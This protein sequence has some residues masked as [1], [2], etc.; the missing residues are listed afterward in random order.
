MVVTVVIL[1]GVVFGLSRLWQSS[2]TASEATISQPIAIVN[3]VAITRQ[4]VDRELKVS[5]LNVAAPLPPLTGADLKRAGEEALNQLIT[6][7]LI[8]QAATWQGFTL[9]DEFIAE[10]ARLLFGSREDE[11]LKSA[12]AHVEA[13]YADLLWWVGEI[14]TIEEFTTQ[15]IMA[16]AAPAKRQQVYN[17]WFNAQR[18]QAK[19]VTYAGG[20]AQVAQAALPGEVATNFTLTTPNGQAISLSDYAGKVVLVN[21]WA[22]WCLSCISEMPDYEQVYQQK[23]P[24]LVVLGINLQEEA[25]HAQQYAAG[26]GVTFPILMDSDGSV[27]TR[28]YQVTGMPGSFIIDRNGVIFYRHLGP[29][30][31]ETLTAK[32]AE[33]GL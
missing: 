22:T 8:L 2:S 23:S 17:E 9:D 30:N 28:H 24:E 14:I 6:R 13:S 27:T 7:Q 21:F 33:L 1:F 19:I 16:G 26:L 25:N 15:V 12:L 3:G 32:L 20:E 18:A 4:M 29:M 10:R 5:R 11:T 31:V